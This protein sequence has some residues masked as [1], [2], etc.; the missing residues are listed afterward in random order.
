MKRI[1]CCKWKITRYFI[2]ISNNL[3]HDIMRIYKICDNRFNNEC[4]I[5]EC[6]VIISYTHKLENEMEGPL[7]PYRDPIM[8]ILSLIPTNILP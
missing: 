2:E 6:F 1:F 3:I 5:E 7:P 8:R 4:I